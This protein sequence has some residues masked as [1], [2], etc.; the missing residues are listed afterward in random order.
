MLTGNRRVVLLVSFSASLLDNLTPGFDFASQVFPELL[1][2]P[3]RNI[4]TLI[5]ESLAQS[6]ITH[7]FCESVV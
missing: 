4:K 3:R 2:G 6:G 1:R 7:A 5:R